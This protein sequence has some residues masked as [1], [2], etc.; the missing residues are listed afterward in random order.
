M[1]RSR[2]AAERR[3]AS[4]RATTRNPTALF[5]HLVRKRKHVCRNVETNRLGGLEIEDELIPDGQLHWQVARLFALENTI[6]IG[7]GL[8][9]QVREIVPYDASRPLSTKSRYPDIEGSRFCTASLAI[10]SPCWLVT[11]LGHTQRPP[12]GRCSRLVDTSG[13]L[14]LILLNFFLGLRKLG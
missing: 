13:E 10:S 9:G 14:A 5:D 4:V 12:F 8:A 7:R 6:D 1:T 3:A 2:H 11:P